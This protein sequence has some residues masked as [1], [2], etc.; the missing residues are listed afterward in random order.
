MKNQLD[1][2]FYLEPPELNQRGTIEI[3]ALAP[4]SMVNSL[5][6][7]YFGSELKPTE[8]MIMGLLENALGWHFAKEI[9]RST[10]KELASTA[11]KKHRKDPIYKDHPWLSGKSESTS[12]STYFSLLQYHLNVNEVN[13]PKVMTYDDFWS[14]HLRDTGTSFYGGSRNYDY[15]LE[16]LITRLR[17]KTEDKEDKTEFG[18]TA[19][20]KKIALEDVYHTKERKINSKS[21]RG[22]YP[23]H[24]VSPKKRGYV[25]PESAY[26]CAISLTTELAHLFNE[27]LNNPS[28][29]TYLGHSESWVSVKW[30]PDAEF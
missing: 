2:S 30:T 19:K 23:M 8:H 12:N 5:P 7:T 13:L 14:M 27:Q 29:P 9:R 10:L 17:T 28:A 15:R 24:Y 1:L 3:T 18:D 6:G 21:V 26:I 4:L 16:E 11:K 25:I 20:F 22:G